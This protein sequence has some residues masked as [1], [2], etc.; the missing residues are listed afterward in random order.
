MLQQAVLMQEVG[1]QAGPMQGVGEQAVPMQDVGE[2]AVL[3][4]LT[5]SA[6]E[7]MQC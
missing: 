2:Q 3:A 1:E 5:W 7:A 4:A 6:D